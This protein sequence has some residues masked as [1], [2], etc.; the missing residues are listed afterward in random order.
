MPRLPGKTAIQPRTDF[1]TPGVHVADT[2]AA[3]KG[4]SSLGLSMQKAGEEITKEDQGMDL[5]RADAQFDE[6]LRKRER[7]FDNDTDHAT[8]ETRFD[9][10]SNQAM[11]DA[12]KLIRD[13]GLREKWQL[14]RAGSKRQAAI[15]RVMTRGRALATEEKEVEVGNILQGYQGRYA[16]TD[17]PERRRQVL[18]D[19]DAAIRVGEATGLLRP[20][21]I[22]RLREQYIDGAIASDG[23][24]RIYNGD[25]EGVLRDLGMVPGGV[26]RRKVSYGAPDLGSV[27]A[28]YESGEG[29]VGFISS[30]KDD[31]GGQ[32]YGV[33]QL[34]SKD[35]MPAFLRSPEGKKYASRFAR[36]VVGSPTFNQT[37]RDIAREDPEGFA[38]AQFE[39][40][41]RTHYQPALEAAKA[42]GF[43]VTD[44]GVQE[45]IFSIGV[46]HGGARKI[47]DAAAGAGDDPSAQIEALY[48]ERS[49][50][51]AGLRDLPGRTKQAVLNR[52]KGEVRDALKLAGTKAG[53]PRSEAMADDEDDG[54]GLIPWGEATEI[55]ED[56]PSRAQYRMLSG[57]QRQTLINKARVALSA[58]TQADVKSDIERLEN[59]EEEL[60]DE[61][62]ETAFD[63]AQRLLTP[64]QREKLAQERDRAIMVRDSVKPIRFMH[65]DDI[66]AHIDRIGQGAAD[67]RYGVVAKVREKAIKEWEKVTEE[68]RKDPAKS[69]AS[70]PIVRAALEREN[71]GAG[72]IGIGVNEH[73]DPVFDLQRMTPDQAQKAGVAT[74]EARLAAQDEIGIPKSLQRTLSKEQARRLIT[75]PPDADPDTLEKG[76][77][78]AAVK[79]AQIYGTQADI[80]GVPI[81]ERVLKD[82]IYLNWPGKSGDTY[83]GYLDTGRSAIATHNKTEEMRREAR[84]K[85]LAKT[86]FGQPITDEDWQK[87]R[88]EDRW[89]TQIGE[90][91]SFTEGSGMASDRPYVGREYTYEGAPTGSR[92]SVGIGTAEVGPPSRGGWFSSAK[93]WERSGPASQPGTYREAPPAASKVL[94]DQI[95]KNPAKA[96]EFRERFDLRY[97]DGAAM[98]VIGKMMQGGGKE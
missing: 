83:S 14:S 32:S 61:R 26:R 68:R 77:Q 82:A 63:R 23:D 72:G 64:N 1:S 48:R 11:L 93:P 9:A 53:D 67:D 15:D 44:R 34:S 5:I 47:I 4:V 90:V 50:Y 12:G 19:M 80:D 33:H 17:D 86:Y 70:H 25:A 76:L 37:Y 42:A 75:V 6:E 84:A 59:G 21:T 10:E 35:S 57:R 8:Y 52:Y 28:K 62:G 65:E 98:R 91:P 20:K 45:A 85:L 16:E 18:A 30:G 13:P 29:G 27:S 79:A 87:L 49:R 78:A 73:G 24:A 31:P 58:K 41:A 66:P 92:G 94:L 39:F 89:L 36:Q 22:E 7:A 96:A 71:I 88:R 51:V 38:K 69:V 46:Q 95:A 2:S 40:Y 55:E 60:V 56:S 43:D 74:V 54:T 3:F 97:G 81:A